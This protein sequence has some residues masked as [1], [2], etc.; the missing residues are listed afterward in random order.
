MI[1]CLLVNARSRDLINLFFT[2]GS[3][4]KRACLR[5]Q[6]AKAKKKLRRD[7]AGSESRPEVRG[8]SMGRNLDRSG[9]SLGWVR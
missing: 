9:C 3:T 6:E 7:I 4:W 8:T 2:F 1:G 5:I